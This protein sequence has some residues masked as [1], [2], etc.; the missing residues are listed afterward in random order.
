MSGYCSAACVTC[1]LLLVLSLLRADHAEKRCDISSHNPTDTETLDLKRCSLS[2]LPPAIVEF[3]RLKKLDLGFNGLTELPALP[4]SLEILFLLANR[5]EAVPPQVSSLPSLRMLSFKS[6]RLK[7]IDVPLPVSLKWLI[8]TDNRLAELPH[9]LGEL[10][11]MRKLMLSN[12][13]LG[14]LP[15]S[16]A[17]LTE[18][19]LLRLANN[20]LRR[21]PEW[22][23]AL[24]LLGR[25]A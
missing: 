23:H 13:R 12:N 7:V 19:E 1:T 3:T 10:K 5:F 18:L 24:P 4:P 11:E 20:R 16:M 8:L 2:A 17:A 25:L 15:R 9:Q 14:A 6:C 21:L 22:L